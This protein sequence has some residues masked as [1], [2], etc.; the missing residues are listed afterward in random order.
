MLVEVATDKL[1]KLAGATPDEG[2]RY[3]SCQLIF[4]VVVVVGKLNNR[5][6]ITNKFT[7]NR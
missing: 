5:M 7:R 2:G 6:Q 4:V 1:S 3:G